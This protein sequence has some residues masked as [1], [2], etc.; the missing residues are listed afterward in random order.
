MLDFATVSVKEST[1]LQLWHETNGISAWASKAFILEEAE[2]LSAEP[3]WLGK[4]PQ[5]R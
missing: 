5:T 1:K 3:A 2:S 4:L